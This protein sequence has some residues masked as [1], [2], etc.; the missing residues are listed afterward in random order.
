MAKLFSRN[1]ANIG[2][3]PAAVL[4]ILIGALVVGY[5]LTMTS[6][7]KGFVLIIL[8]LIFI[9]TFLWPELG[10][11]LVI[12]SMLLSP[13]IIA[14]DIGGKATAG[15]GL[16]LRLEDFLLLFIGL[17]WLARTALDKTSGL[18]QKTP[19]NQPI[20]AYIMVCLVATLWGKIT[21]DVEGK[22]GFFFVL[23]YFEFMIVFFLVV[24]YVDSAD[25]AK[26]LI[27]VFFS[28]VSLS[29]FTGS[30][31][32]PVVAGL[33]HHSKANGASPTPLAVT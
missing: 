25:Q 21:G 29:P 31:R 15:R 18:L 8:L 19:L 7:I 1:T 16:T 12:F 3:P 17:S 27:S 30:S 4:T 6:A 23:K 20:A 2:A 26:R 28:P 9:C 13:E 32:Y 5:L 33:A 22:A 10:L 11:Y 24:N 14:S